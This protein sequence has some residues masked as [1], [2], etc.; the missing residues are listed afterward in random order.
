MAK[1]L[2]VQYGDVVLF[3]GP[4]ERLNFQ[5]S[6]PG[7]GLPVVEMRIGPNSNALQQFLLQQAQRA[8]ENNEKRDTSAPVSLTDGKAGA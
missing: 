7:N 2:T 5:E 4:I 1:T 8:K 3:S 6:D